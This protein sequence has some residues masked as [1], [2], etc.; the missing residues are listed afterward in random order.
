[1]VNFLN[2]EGDM[3]TTFQK[4]IDDAAKQAGS[5]SALSRKSGISLRTLQDWKAGRRTPRDYAQSGIIEALKRAAKS[6]AIIAILILASS[7]GQSSASSGARAEVVIA[8]L[9]GYQ[10][11][12]IRDENGAAVGGNCV[13]E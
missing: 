3:K 10:C 12:V 13:R 4:K 6:A 5:L 2:S 7:C 8:P 9:S 11:F 1:M